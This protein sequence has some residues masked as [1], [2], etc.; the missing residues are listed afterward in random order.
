MRLAQRAQIDAELTAQEAQVAADAEA[1][2]LIQARY[3]HGTASELDVLTSEAA[4]YTAQEAL[5]G[6][7]LLKATNL[8]ALYQALGGGLS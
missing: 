7:R 1:V 2:G 4:F 6:V 5:T 3:S 8:V